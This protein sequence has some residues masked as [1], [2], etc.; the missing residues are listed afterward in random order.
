MDPA[1]APDGA[2]N[3]LSSPSAARRHALALIAITFVAGLLRLVY[4]HQFAGLPFFDQPVGESAVHLELARRIA[5]GALLPERPFFY[6]SV[7]YP[8]F[9]AGVLAAGGS[10]FIVCLIQ[11]L[12]GTALVPLLAAIAGRLYGR[13][14]GL[15]T[16]AVTAI[17]GP[18]AFMEADV[19]GIVWALVGLALALLLV[20]RW[21]DSDARSRAPL[22][23]VVA[24]AALGAAAA[25][26]PNLVLLVP[27]VAGW[28]AWR[29][30][31]SRARPV[32]AVALG[33]AA[34]IALVVLLNFAAAGQWIP[35]ATSRGLNL[36]MGFNP[37]ANGTYVEPWERDDPQFHARHTEIEEASLEMASRLSGRALTPEQASDYWTARAL[38]FIRTHPRESIALVTRKAALLLNAAEMPNHLDFA[39]IRERAPAL[40]AMPLGFGAVAP[41]A[42][43]GLCVAWRER[44]RRAPTLL[45]VLVTATVAASVLPF[46][47]ADRY[48]AP[49][50][51]PLLV[52]AGAGA[53][54]LLSVLV[55]P[56]RSLDRLAV[57]MV[58]AALAVAFIAHVPLVRAVRSRDHWIFAEA[59]ARRGQVQAAAASY[60]AAVREQG[61]DGELLN[62]L[63]LLYRDMGRRDRAEETLRRAIAANP[64]LAYPHKNL[65]MILIRRG[66]LDQAL[67]EIRESLRLE[68]ED[69]E[70]L[71][72]LGALLAE[73][74]AWSEAADAFARARELAPGDARLARL[75]ASYP[76][77]AA[78]AAAS[79]R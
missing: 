13:A 62:N 54:P 63:A 64:R 74:G 51:P 41:I 10:L 18:F 65:A 67:V 57:S 16:A 44:R 9:L 28:C 6:A 43:A 25:E 7:F 35:L 26:R 70:A 46:F 15:V 32:V 49:M 23:L 45:L 73:R 29:S 17:Y 21:S 66:A 3:P 53:V 42:A 1:R 40:W 24:G 8:Y 60:E 50:V 11:V 34:P 33:A 47:V 39:F 71:G 2:A 5:A 52:L 37:H 56:R 22:S 79:R 55:R 12:A 19:V 59:Y 48:R 38:D 76:D 68:P 20:L 61:D 36:Y 31:A 27:L 69:A 58:G 14:S 75:I 72:A 4:L 30:T 77:V 78:R